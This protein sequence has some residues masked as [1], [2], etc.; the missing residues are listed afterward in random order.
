MKTRGKK[1]ALLSIL[2]LLAL[3]F[4]SG[5]GAR[6]STRLILDSDFSG[7]RIITCVASKSDVE[8]NFEGGVGGIDAVI[9]QHCPS[10]LTCTK[11]ED[12]SSYTY[13][14]TMTFSSFEDYKLQVESLLGRSSEITFRQP[15][16]VFASGAALE[17]DFSSLDLLGWF[18]KVVEEEELMSNSSNLWELSDTSVVFDGEEFS[19]GGT[20]QFNHIESNPITAIQ[21][22]THIG[23][24]S[25]ER[26]VS[27]L[28]PERAGGKKQEE[29]DAYMDSLMPEGASGEW[30][31]SEE[32]DSW[33]FQI[34]WTAASPD[35]FSDGMVSIF[36]DDY[37][38]NSSLDDNDPFVTSQYIQESFPV[39][40]FSSETD[41]SL[42]VYCIYEL[43]EQDDRR[44]VLTGDG[45]NQEEKRVLFETYSSSVS[46]DFHIDR[47]S[48][49][50]QI[51]FTMTPAD[52]DGVN[53]QIDFVFPPEN[54][55]MA[56]K[57]A[58]YYGALW[59][60][61]GVETL[62]EEGQICRLTLPQ[63]SYEAEQ[64]LSEL[65]GGDSAP[66]P[67]LLVTFRKEAFKS[68][69][70]AGF[71]CYFDPLL[72]RAG[73]TENGVNFTFNPSGYRMT[74]VRL[75]NDSTTDIS[76]PV[77]INARMVSLSIKAEKL[78]LLNIVLL[79]GGIL[80]LLAALVVGYLFLVKYMAKRD[81]RQDEPLT[82]L[83]RD[84]FFISCRWVWAKLTVAAQLAGKGIGILSG[85]VA[86]QMQRF[87]PEGT[88]VKLIRYFYGSRGPFFLALLVLIVFPIMGQIAVFAAFL[89]TTITRGNLL[90][91]MSLTGF[92]TSAEVFLLTWGLIIAV[93]WYLIDRFRPD[94]DAEAEYDRLFAEGTEQFTSR[95]ALDRLALVPEQIAIAE[96]LSLVG[97]DYRNKDQKLKWFNALARWIRRLFFYE[98]RLVVKK[99]SDGVW[100]YSCATRSIWFLSQNQLFLFK[101]S[102]DVCTNKVFRESTCETFYQDLCLVESRELRLHTSKTARMPVYFQEF[103]VTSASGNT[104]RGSIDSGFTRSEQVVQT[105]LAIQ[106]LAREKKDEI[107][108]K[109]IRRKKI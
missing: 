106:N 108:Q 29:V 2:L 4:L 94:P 17:E 95:I 89:F 32:N 26:T 63:N 13:T 16:S 70:D 83:A 81:Q 46:T 37:V 31:R 109:K 45:W 35:G 11:T 36:G 97:P 25:C 73:I 5:C 30:V 50:D 40:T 52:M 54:P 14:F 85:A 75:N 38:C 55:E 87:Y 58:N 98:P 72:N 82:V 3:L 41:G 69:W 59:E 105:T 34:T 56:E 92:V 10:N 33:L 8:N 24:S 60:D 53:I 21:V 27:F 67:W 78:N 42:H 51:A 107:K 91:V 18:K 100:R 6:V 65:L 90:G 64:R 102:Y 19:T 1:Q 62:S 74:E 99:G 77:S 88:S 96:P 7:S 49:V 47:Q 12:D 15:D 9:S 66:S 103:L 43:D 84:Y 101:V 22:E 44:L 79:V 23:Q 93:G 68:N 80:L 28:M 104:M 39:D 61:V 86:N 76:G 71:Q 20:I 57:A 48:Q